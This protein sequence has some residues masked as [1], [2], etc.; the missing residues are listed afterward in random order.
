MLPHDLLGVRRR[1]DV[2]GQRLHLGGAVDVADDDGARDA[3][4]STRAKRS[5]GQPLGE[6]AARLEVR[7]DDDLVGVQDLRGLGHEVDAGEADDVGLRL[8]RR[9]REL[10]R[11]ADEVGDV[12]DLATP[13][14]SARG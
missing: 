10:E 2:V 7:Q 8:R 12:L 3:A 5:A 1:D 6:R 4:P 13:G 14:S 9:L 11:V